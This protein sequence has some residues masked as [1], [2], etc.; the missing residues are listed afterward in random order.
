MQTS[1]FYEDVFTGEVIDLSLVNGV[2]RVRVE[3]SSELI[4]VRTSFLRKLFMNETK[5]RVYT[6]KPSS[7]Y[8]IQLVSKLVCTQ[9]INR[10]PLSRKKINLR[11]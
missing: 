7:N 1:K 5:K 8:T 11:K 4:V 9:K 3:E 6:L 2:T 10:L